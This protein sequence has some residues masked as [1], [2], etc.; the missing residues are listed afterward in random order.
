[1]IELRLTPEDDLADILNNLKEPAAI[2]LKKGIYRQ[3]VK[4]STDDVELIGED[5]ETMQEKYMPT[6][7]NTTLSA[8]IRFA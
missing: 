8:P 1:M 4:I 3:K 2:Y 7:G 6:A 5:R